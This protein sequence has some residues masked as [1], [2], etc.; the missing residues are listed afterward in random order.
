MIS[1]LNI[2]L[3]P[4]LLENLTRACLG[5][6]LERIRRVLSKIIVTYKKIDENSISILL[7]EKKQIIRQTEILEYWSSSE[8]IQNIGGVD[9]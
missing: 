3:K 8:T 2:E 5:L 7:N 1:S 6:S 9:I 4:S